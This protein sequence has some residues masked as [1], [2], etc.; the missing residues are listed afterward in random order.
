[1]TQSAGPERNS[2]PSPRRAFAAQELR[3]LSG[4]LLLLGLG[5]FF[6]LP[7]V[8]SI[9]TVVFLTSMSLVVVAQLLIVRKS[10]K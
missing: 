9:G 2:F 8:L 3:L 1:M 4:L 6:A 7:F 10:A 5:L